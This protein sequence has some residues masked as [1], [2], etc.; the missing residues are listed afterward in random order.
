MTIKI[1]LVH[2]ISL[3]MQ[4]SHTWDLTRV[5]DQASELLGTPEPLPRIFP[6]PPSLGDVCVSPGGSEGA[7][8]THVFISSAPHLCTKDGR[9]WSYPYL[10]EEKAGAHGSEAKLASLVNVRAG[11]RIQEPCISLLGL[12]SPS[13]TNWVA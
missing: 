12:P 9:Y 13:I 2:I 5:F 7:F 11:T 4:T 6:P 10:A 8:H 3:P 1:P